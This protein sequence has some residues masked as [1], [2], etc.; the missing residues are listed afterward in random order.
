MISTISLLYNKKLL[1]N[2]KSLEK[3]SKKTIQS[4]G[5][6]ISDDK[7]KLIFKEIMNLIKYLP[8]FGEIINNIISGSVSGISTIVIGY[9]LVKKYER[10]IKI[11]YEMNLF[12]EAIEGF[13]DA[14]EG[15]K[16]LK[17]R[18]YFE[19]N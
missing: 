13:N 16:K 10:E 14:V 4:L 18:I 5:I 6:H 1:K 8:Y 12:L 11:N 2:K 9:N 3:I 19:T 7:I 17:E 15:I